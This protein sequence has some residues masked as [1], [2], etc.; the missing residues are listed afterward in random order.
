MRTGFSTAATRIAA[1]AWLA[2]HLGWHGLACDLCDQVLWKCHRRHGTKK[3]I[4]KWCARSS[5]P[6]EVRRTSKQ[7]IYS[8]SMTKQ[9][10]IINPKS[11]PNIFCFCFGSNKTK[12]N[13]NDIESS[14]GIRWSHLGQT[15]FVWFPNRG[16][17]DDGKW[18]KC[19]ARIELKISSAIEHRNTHSRARKRRPNEHFFP[20]N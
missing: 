11:A 9:L 20:S 2:A 8:I 4:R 12:Q 19:E 7:M 10:Q 3:T 6:K 1:F 15:E 5:N 17:D 18:Q 13:T 14:E 16:I